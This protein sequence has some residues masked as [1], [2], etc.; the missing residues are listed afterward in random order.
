MTPVF[1]FNIE[2]GSDFTNTFNW[3]GGG[4]RMAP[5]EDIE[6]GYPTRIQ[7]TAHGLPTVSETPVIISG[8]KGCPQLNSTDLGIEQMTP[9]GPDHFLA[10]ISTVNTNWEPGTG[11]VTWHDV[12]DISGCT[13]RMQIRKSWHSK[14]IIYEMTTEN[15][16]IKLT[17][18]DASIEIFIPA[19]ITT[20]FAFAKAFYDIEVI[21]PAG[22]ITRVVKGQ[23]TLI[24][25]ITR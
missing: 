11:E 14:D 10:P 8:V 25:E 16:G 19:A 7:V 24:R 3:Y 5:I 18:D 20:D 9:D 22:N 21:D 12:T 2:Q 13:A 17:V 1:D 15:S 6:V 23:L 4:K